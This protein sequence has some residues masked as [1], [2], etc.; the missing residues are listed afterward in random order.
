MESEI[1]LIC[2]LFDIES[3]SFILLVLSFLVLR[4]YQ[5]VKLGLMLLISFTVLGAI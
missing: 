5:A 3:N 1:R 4:F 2:F